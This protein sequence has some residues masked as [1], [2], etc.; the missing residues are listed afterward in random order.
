MGR[1]V[2]SVSMGRSGTAIWSAYLIFPL[3]GHDLGVGTRDTNARIHAG[4]VVSLNDVAAED[5]ASS[6]ATV[7][8]TLGARESIF[9][10]AVWPAIRAKKCVLLFETKPDFVAGI[11]VHQSCRFVA[12]VELVWCSIGI[13]RL[14]HDQDIVTQ[15]DGV[16]EGCDWSDV[17]IGIV[18]GSLAGGGSVK[19]PLWEVFDAVWLFEESLDWLSS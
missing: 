2:E 16:W 13:P 15:T 19:V 17:D 7:V 14:T 5:T 10:P 9:R 12:I 1:P 18:A 6:H 11:R 3:R 4:L 8:W